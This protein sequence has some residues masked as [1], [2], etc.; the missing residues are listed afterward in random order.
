M[1]A[2][3][4]EAWKKIVNHTPIEGDDV[5]ITEES[6]VAYP[7]FTPVEQALLTA[8][9]ALREIEIYASCGMMAGV[10]REAKEALEMIS[11]TAHQVENTTECEHTDE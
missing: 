9:H 3:I 5:E 7:A 2:N 11:K 8:Y 4:S 1:S 6:E 10:E